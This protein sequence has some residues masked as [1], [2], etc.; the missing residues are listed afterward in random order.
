MLQER[1]RVSVEIARKRLNLKS[2]ETVRRLIKSGKLQAVV[3]CGR[4]QVFVDSIE[5]YLESNVIDP[6]VSTM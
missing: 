6:T 4:F 1:K 3:I 5:K 2:A